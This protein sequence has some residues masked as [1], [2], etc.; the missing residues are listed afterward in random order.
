MRGLA[1]REDSTNNDDAYTRNYIRLNLLPMIERDINSSAVEHLAQFGQ[2]MRIVREREDELSV[3]LFTM[4][5]V[6]E[7]PVLTLS[8]KSLRR[9]DNLEKSLVIREAGRRLSLRT[10]SRERCTDL[11]GLMGRSGRF[12]FQWCDGVTLAARDGILTFEYKREH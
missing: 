2:D 10:L 4:C 8:I 3:K 12:T 11:A 7:S 1:W 6:S 9:L 5:L